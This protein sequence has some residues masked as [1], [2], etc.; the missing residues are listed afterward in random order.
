MKFVTYE[1]L[2]DYGITAHKVSIWRWE[3]A[4]QF[5]KRVQ[6][7]PV[8]HAWVESEIRQ[9]LADRIAARDAALVS[10]AA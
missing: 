8:R 1:N 3:R 7:S 9:W 5:P 2:R 6:I 4:G 10:E